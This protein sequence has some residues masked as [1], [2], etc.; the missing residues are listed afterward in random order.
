MPGD[1]DA[2]EARRQ[3]RHQ[4]KNEALAYLA[5]AEVLVKQAQDIRDRFAR[6]LEAEA[7]GGGES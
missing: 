1:S 5:Q 2:A 3:V 7:A 4:A 6:K